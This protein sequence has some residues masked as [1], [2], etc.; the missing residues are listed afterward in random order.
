MRNSRNKLRAM[1]GSVLLL[2][3]Q[4]VFALGLGAVEVRSY[5]GEPLHARVDL[6]NATA[7]ELNSMTAALATAADIERLGLTRTVSV[8]LHFRVNADPADAY[9]EISSRL[10][11]NE[12]VV[13]LVLQVLWSGGR[14][15]REYNLFLDPPT[16]AARAPGPRVSTKPLPPAPESYPDPDGLDVVETVRTPPAAVVRPV[17]PTVPPEVASPAQAPAITQ[18]P[19]VTETPPEPAPEPAAPTPPPVTATVPADHMLEEAAAEASSEVVLPG[20]EAPAVSDEYESP[21]ATEPEVQDESVTTADVVDVPEPV[22]EPAPERTVEGKPEALADSELS[23]EPEPAPTDTALAAADPSGE[24][25]PVQR[26]ETLWAIAS[27]YTRGTDYS[28]NQAMLAIQRLNPEAFGGNNINSLKRGAILRMPGMSEVGRLD[29]RQAMLEA[30]R[31]EQAYAAMRAGLPYDDS[32]PLLADVALEEVS[33]TPAT[34]S[35]EPAPAEEEVALLELVPPSSGEQTPG[36][37]GDEQTEATGALSSEELE[38]VLARTEEELAN[39]QQENAYLA[40]RIRELEERLSTSGEEGGIQNNEMAALES[41]LQEQRLDPGEPEA[42]EP[43]TDEPAAWVPWAAAILVA[44][45]VF[46]VWLLRRM[47]AGQDRVGGDESE[48]AAV[49]GI[50]NEAEEILKTLDGNADEKDAAGKVVE[51]DK[52]ASGTR[53]KAKP[54]EDNEVIELDTSDPETQLD[55]ARAYISMGDEDAARSM[56]E[57]VLE[58]GDESQVAEAREM[59]RELPGDPGQ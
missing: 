47:T 20:G 14:M 12:P 39:A 2:I 16:I 10:P 59:M 55:L 35:P 49:G 40:E 19:V 3:S 58:H 38:E 13:Q 54:L 29:R 9:V 25:G 53:R 48:L 56:L 30:M 33:E 52:P 22:V 31:Q 36:G 32:P 44:L 1:L 17:A 57:S 27:G 6:I 18:E 28:V 51:L 50:R 46:L 7:E 21:G 15:L 45:L 24:Y 43:D 23:V 42:L 41:G 26:G 34:P 11:L 5:L 37:T 8:P 4:G